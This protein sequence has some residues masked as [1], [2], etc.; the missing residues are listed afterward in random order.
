[1][2]LKK[3]E[4][5]G[6]DIVEEHIQQEVQRLH[7]EEEIQNAIEITE[8]EEAVAA[9]TTARQVDVPEDEVI[10][11]DIQDEQPVQESATN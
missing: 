11:E 4:E 8:T 5:S 6:G 1:M 3:Q 9:H 7:M 2:T 10:I